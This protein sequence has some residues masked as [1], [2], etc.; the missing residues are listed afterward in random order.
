MAFR[1][2]PEQH[3]AWATE[4]LEL[5]TRS[6]PL[7]AS[8]VWLAVKGAIPDS[9]IRP[10]LGQLVADG[11]ATVE[12]KTRYER[13]GNRATRVQGRVYSAAP[14]KGKGARQRRRATRKQ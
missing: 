12:V 3:E 6:G 8:E 7:P 11:R 2:S 5:L 13:V 1:Y 14:T 9:K 4:I 10:L